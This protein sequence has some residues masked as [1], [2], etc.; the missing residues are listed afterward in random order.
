MLL[1]SL[2]S[3]K[4]ISTKRSKAPRNSVTL[5]VNLRVLPLASPYIR[6]CRARRR[7]GWMAPGRAQAAPRRDPESGVAGRRARRVDP[8]SLHFRKD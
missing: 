4:H 6:N 3:V 5:A 7:G 1:P 2:D 8:T